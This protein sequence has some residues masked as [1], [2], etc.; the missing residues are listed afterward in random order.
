MSM[1]EGMN[2][3]SIINYYINDKKWKSFLNS[4][5]VMFVFSLKKKWIKVKIIVDNYSDWLQRLELH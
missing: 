3:Y 5:S 1:K 4:F 2:N